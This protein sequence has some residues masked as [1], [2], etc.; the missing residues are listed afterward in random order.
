ML[1][2]ILA[3]VLVLSPFVIGFFVALN[4]FQNW[5]EK[6]DVCAIAIVSIMVSAIL[7]GLCNLMIYCGGTTTKYLEQQKEI[8]SLNNGNLISGNFILGCGD[9]D[10][11]SYY[12]CFERQFDGG[13]KRI[14]LPANTSTIYEGLKK[15]MDSPC[16]TYN[17]KYHEYEARVGL[18][19]SKIKQANRSFP[20][21]SDREY[22]IYI[23]TNSIVREFNPN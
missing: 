21:E 11:Q 23:P 13:L 6:E 15:G 18:F 20:K 12:F 19:G 17:E 16:V 1:L 8:V 3:H 14:N 4:S 5:G 7:V 9:I 22:K 10:Q 2:Y